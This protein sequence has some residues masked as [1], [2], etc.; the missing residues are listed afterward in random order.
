[1][2]LLFATTGDNHQVKVVVRA[3]DETDVGRCRS[4]VRGRLH[5]VR[6]M[7]ELEEGLPAADG[8]VE[9]ATARTKNFRVRPRLHLPKME[10][11]F[12]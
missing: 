5:A 1:M 7:A 10:A 11:A 4:D 12:I 8:A 3:R 6:A 2:H 9:A